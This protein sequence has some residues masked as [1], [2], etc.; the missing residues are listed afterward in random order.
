MFKL[1][2]K[3]RI[4]LFLLVLMSIGLVITTL[5]SHHPFHWKHPKH[6]ANTGSSLSSD[7]AYCPICG[8]TFK[9][10]K[11]PVFQV[12]QFF[13]CYL[14]FVL[15]TDH[16]FVSAFYIPDLGRAPPLSA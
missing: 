7:S 14:T 16:P 9:G 5:H 6:L 12:T 2:I 10:N 15:P 4:S 1:K 13:R 3:K 8:Y 11:A